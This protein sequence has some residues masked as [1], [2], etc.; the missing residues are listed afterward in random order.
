MRGT[1]LVFADF[2]VHLPKLMK[3]KLFRIYIYLIAVLAA[4]FG[5]SAQVNTDQVIRIGQNAL[6]FED[7]MLSIQYFNQAIQAKPYLA[8]PY[9]LRAIA[10]LNLE[11][12]NGAEADASKA[13]EINPYLS[14][15]WEVRGVARQNLGRNTDAIDDYTKALEYIPRNRQLMFNRALALQDIKETERAAKAFDEVIEYYP[16]FDN[17]YLG[18][19]RLRMERGDTVAALEDINKALSINKNAINA[20]I[21]RADI[22]I[23]SH[24]DYQGAVA[25]IDNAIRLQPRMAGLYINRAYL[26]YNLDSYQGA[27]D[28]YD[29]A[30]TLEP[31]NVTALFNR[32]LLLAEVSDNDRA[33]AD[34]DR[35]L[36]LDPENFRALYNRAIIYREKGNYDAAIA[37]I[38]RVAEKF[39][40]FP[41][42]I[43][44]RADLYRQKGQLAAAEADY[45]KARALA[46]ALK[47]VSDDETASAVSGDTPAADENAGVPED[48]VARRFASL[49]TVDDNATIEEEYNNSAIRGRVQDRRLNIEIE[50]M[51]LLSFYSSPTE[52]RRNTYYIREVDDIN[53]TRQLRF[54]LV[55]TNDVPSIDESM[56]SR[57][58]QS[59]DYY[60]S[61][62]ATHTPRPVDYIGRA[63]DFITVRDYLNAEKDIDRAIALAPDLAIAHLIRAQ[64]LYGRL[65]LERDTPQPGTDAMM[66]AS[67]NRKKLQDIADELDEVI[68]LSPNM[69]IAYFNKGNI[70]FELEEYALASRAYDRAIELKPD[71]GEAYYN[72]GYIALRSGRQAEGVADLSKAGELGVIPAYNLIK[73]IS[74]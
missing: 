34:F 38:S 17:G 10:K 64:A 25:D 2:F 5:A 68:R 18:R 13:I 32:G 37:D 20:Y 57:H 45:K 51:M 46:K 43:G 4:S 24:R 65:Q 21:M 14:D 47:P 33:L 53:A 16:G 71:F 58:F 31:L 7:Y 44:L 54:V 59:I 9:F 61:H 11:D 56:A 23:N 69:A 49:L 19:A 60:N 42:A 26:K 6:Y 62:L 67:L 55:V 72:R 41:G 39:P 27:M 29:Y 66:R 74:R 15:A 22:A 3:M 12:Y 70:L 50:P 52:L 36:E 8:Q 73:R 35:V 1:V 28:D 48:L 30:L 40:D 63:L